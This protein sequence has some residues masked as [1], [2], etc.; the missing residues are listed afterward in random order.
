MRSSWASYGGHFKHADSYRSLRRLWE[1]HPISQ[2]YLTLNHSFKLRFAGSSLDASWKKQVKRLSIGIQDAVLMIKVGCYVECPLV[3][4]IKRLNLR[5]FKRKRGRLK[6]GFSKQRTGV[7][8]KKCLRKGWSVIWAA[9]R[10]FRAGSLK[11]RELT[12]ALIKIQLRA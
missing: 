7:F 12:Y 10:S 1:K 2:F 5:W 6:A 3:R 8:I 11:L 9:E 4:D